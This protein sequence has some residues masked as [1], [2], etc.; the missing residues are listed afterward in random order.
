MKITK[1]SW[2]RIYDIVLEPSDR[3]GQLPEDTKK[4]PL[5]MWT[6]GFLLQDAMIGDKVEIRTITGR[7]T[8]GTLVEENPYYEHDFGK[9]VPE[10][11]PIGIQLRE[12]L[13]GGEGDE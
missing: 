4:V 13:W 7:R 3:S 8:E 10:I 2:V 5:E 12:I 11:L 6:K 1:G 9:F